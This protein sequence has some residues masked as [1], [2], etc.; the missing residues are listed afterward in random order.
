M[1]L[2]NESMSGNPLE[3]DPEREHRIR[4]RA[5]HLWN[6]EGR[7]HGRD[8]EFWE[9]ARELIGMEESGQAGQ[10]PNPESSGQNPAQEQPVEQA[11]VQENLGEFPDRFADQGEAQPAPKPKRTARTTIQAPE[12]PGELAANPAAKKAAEKAPERLPAKPSLKAKVLKE[13][14]QKAPAKDEKGAPKRKTRS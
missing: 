14:E 2:E 6:D 10:A 5:Y 3:S 13:K 12:R 11:S 4:E 7:P 1:E 8:H 9:R